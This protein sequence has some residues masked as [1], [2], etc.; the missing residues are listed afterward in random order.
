MVL[1]SYA[2]LVF[3]EKEPGFEK[4]ESSLISASE[5]RRNPLNLRNGFGQ[6]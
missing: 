2:L 4:F 3:L 1:D 6:L 5:N